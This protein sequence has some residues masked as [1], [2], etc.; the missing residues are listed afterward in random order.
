MDKIIADLTVRCGNIQLG[1][2]VVYEIYTEISNH[3]EI[4]EAL[5]A[6]RMGW[7]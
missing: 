4:A 2:E 6:R 5:A 7:S 1:P 3:E